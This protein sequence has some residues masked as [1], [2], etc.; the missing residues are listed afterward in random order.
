MSEVFLNMNRT[1]CQRTMRRGAFRGA[2]AVTVR[3]DRSDD[4]GTLAALCE[5]LAADP[6]VAACEVWSALDPAGMPVSTEEKLRGG[7]NKIAGCLMIDTL[8]QD[9]AENLG[10]RMARLFPAADVGVFRVLCRIGRG[11]L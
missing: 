10:A 11:D 9:D 4:T 6:A 1:V 7:D 5:N 2:F 8:R 3:F